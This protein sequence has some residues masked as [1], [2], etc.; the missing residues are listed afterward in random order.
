MRKFVKSEV[1]PKG[2][3]Y[4]VDEQSF[5][6]YKRE[7]RQARAVRKVEGMPIADREPM[8]NPPQETVLP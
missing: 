7:D 5:K 8:M 4:E 2:E 1:A 6:S 3:F